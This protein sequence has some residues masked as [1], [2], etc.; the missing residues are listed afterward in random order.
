MI[1]VHNID[2]N[3][4]YNPDDLYKSWAT[5]RHKISTF[6]KKHAVDGK[7]LVV[8]AGNLNDFNLQGFDHVSL[9][10]IDKEAMI[11]GLKRQSLDVAAYKLLEGDLTGLSQTD[12]FTLIN[13]HEC[14][15]ETYEA[16]EIKIDLELY[17]QIIVLPIYTQLLL[18]QLLSVLEYEA[19]HKFLPL[20]QNRIQNLNQLLRNHLKA[21]GKMIVVSDIL[22]YHKDQEEFDYL[23]A[24]EDHTMIL[25]DF[26]K[27]Y[28]KTFGHGLGSYGIFEMS[29]Y[30][31]SIKEDYFIWPFSDDRLMMV[32][33]QVLKTPD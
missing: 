13:S 29:H 11:Q 30:L 21:S 1:K 4:S 9:L 5:Y 16:T 20:I 22:E 33:A 19:I 6:I 17:D 24:H 23:K 31:T 28:L 14:K 18:P 15:P 2:L 25:D 10:D 26:Y 8:G 27:V 12:F 3:K 32:K 7:L